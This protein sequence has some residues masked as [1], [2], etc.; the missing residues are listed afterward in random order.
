MPS[1]K[2]CNAQSLTKCLSKSFAFFKNYDHCLPN[3]K[4]KFINMY[5]QDNEGVN[6][7]HDDVI[8]SIAAAIILRKLTTPPITDEDGRVDSSSIS[9]TK[10]DADSH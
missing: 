1:A 8:V 9:T 6:Q 10:L 2:F 4:L 7:S 3:L 5:A